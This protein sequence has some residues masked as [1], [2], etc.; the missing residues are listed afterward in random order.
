[1][2]PESMPTSAVRSTPS[3]S[4]TAHADIYIYIVVGV[5][6]ERGR[7]THRGGDGGRRHTARRVATTFGHCPEVLR[8]RKPRNRTII[9]TGEGRGVR[10]TSFPGA[11]CEEGRGKK[12][13]GAPDAAPPNARVCVVLPMREAHALLPRPRTQTHELAHLADPSDT[14]PTLAP[15]LLPSLPSLLPPTYLVGIISNSTGNNMTAH[16]LASNHAT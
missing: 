11:C 2:V 9:P 5:W 6:R 10:P 3:A 13:G 14:P 15:S 4:R 7:H 16:S 12:G 8:R 1:M